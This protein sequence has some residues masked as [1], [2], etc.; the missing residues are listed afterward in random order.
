MTRRMAWAL[1]L[2]VGGALLATTWH[3]RRQT[4]RRPM[5]PGRTIDDASDAVLEASEESFPAS[6]PPSHTPTTGPRF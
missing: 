2:G 3:S 6:D 1:A 5:R 4:L